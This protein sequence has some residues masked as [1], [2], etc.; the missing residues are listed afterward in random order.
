MDVTGVSAAV[1]D[2]VE[3]M[4]ANLPLHDQAQAMGTID[5]EL[6]TRL[7]PRIRRTYVGGA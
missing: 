2:E 5:Y 4:G 6:L 7:G 1:G 3:L